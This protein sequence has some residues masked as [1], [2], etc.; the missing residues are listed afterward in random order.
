MS[1]GVAGR[2]VRDGMMCLN[3]VIVSAVWG[4]LGI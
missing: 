4:L 2:M 3:R 1:A